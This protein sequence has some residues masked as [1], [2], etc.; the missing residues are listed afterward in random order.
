MFI[1][2]FWHFGLIAHMHS[3]AEINE[4]FTHSALIE[5]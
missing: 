1:K 4:I 5:L 2:T 3:V